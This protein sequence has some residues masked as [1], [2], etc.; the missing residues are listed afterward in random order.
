MENKLSTIEEA[1]EDLKA[2][3]MLIVVDNPDRENQ[4]DIIL[5]AQ[6]ATTESINFLLNECRGMICVALTK[7][8]ALRLDLPLMVPPID[9]TEKTRVQFTVTV[10]SKD[11]TAYGISSADRAKTIQTLGSPASI[12]TDLV[13]PG[14]VFPLLARDGGVLERQG[15]TEATTDL[16]RLAGF[17][18]VGVLCEVLKSDGEPARLTEL[19][20][21][22][23]KHN[24]KV[25]SV[26][27]LHEFLG[28]NPLKKPSSLCIKKTAS[29][30]LPTKY[31]TFAMSV[32]KS[33]IDNREHVALVL[34]EPK[35][36]MLTR[37]HSKC[38]TGDTL[39]SEK[40]DCG[41]QLQKS[42]DQIHTAGAGVILY[43]DQ[44]GRGIGLTNKIRAYALQEKGLDTVEA[45]I[46]L[47]FNVD[48][49]NFMIAGEMLCDLGIRKIKLLTNNPEKLSSLEGF[50]IE[51]V[52]HVPLETE[53]NETNKEYLSTK[54][55][56]LGHD[57]KL[58]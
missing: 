35:G 3:K 46:A 56:K 48:E 36:I 5:P 58:V 23:K 17:A 52:E 11:V 21:F 53:P 14:H 39:H 31:G 41:P 38:V 25:I 2:G 16:C 57:L 1:I 9:T 24:L 28:K 44:E 42:M 30:N 6:F 10:D 32:Y 49:R 45:N 8:E 50:G 51:I 26:S 12:A 15:H 47:G 20:E 40:C 7:E 18:P 37:L 27:D 29:A 19:M 34:G 4:G 33:I 54:K 55:N 43:L 22:G 13:R